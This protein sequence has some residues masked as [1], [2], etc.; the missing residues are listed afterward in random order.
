MDRINHIAVP[1]SNIANAVAWYLDSFSCG[2]SYQDDT[3]ALL[4]FENIS[5][6]LVL[7]EQHPGHFAVERKD[8]A[9]FGNLKLHRDKTKSVYIKDPWNNSLEILQTHQNG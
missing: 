8:A 6:A 1:V 5:L 2:V 4:D 9:K 7:P 3:W